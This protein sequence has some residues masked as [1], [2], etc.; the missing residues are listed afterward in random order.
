[1]SGRK[2]GAIKSTMVASRGGPGGGGGA[3]PPLRVVVAPTAA[4]PA[5]KI[6]WT[7]PAS[8][9]AGAP[10]DIG[11]VAASATGTGGPLR[12]EFPLGAFAIGQAG[13]NL[14][15]V[16]PGDGVA[17]LDGTETATVPVTAIP[18]TIVSAMPAAPV[19]RGTA[20]TAAMFSAVPSAG[21]GVVV[22]SQPV[23]AT[24]A[25]VGP[26]TVVLALAAAG[27]H[28][29]APPVSHVIN[30]LLPKRVITW[31]PP[32]SHVYAAPL[33]LVTL[34]ASA[35]GL[36][37]D[38]VLSY[39]QG[40]LAVVQ[41]GINLK[42]TAPG[43]AGEWDAAEETATVAV[44]PAPRTLTATAP[45]R[46]FKTGAVVKASH[47]VA[48]ASAGDEEATVT[49]P[50][51]GKLLVVGGAVDVVL[52]LPAGNYAA[53]T[54]TVQVQVEP[55]RPKLTLTSTA[56]TVVQN[57]Q[58]ATTWL[59]AAIEPDTLAG[60][61]VFKPALGTALAHLGPATISVEFL[62]DANFLRVRP[63][64]VR[65]AICKNADVK[66]GSDDM[67]DATKARAAIKPMYIDAKTT[68]LL[69]NWA[70]DVG[71]VAT[72][73]RKVMEDI[74]NM[75]SDELV[76]YMDK[77]TGRRTAG[78]S[79]D[80]QLWELGNGLQVRYKANGDAFHPSKH[81]CMEVS[82]VA[83]S[84]GPQ[85]IAFK[86]TLGGMPGPVGREVVFPA[87]VAGTTPR[88]DYVNGVLDMTHPRVLAKRKP[89]IDW[90]LADG[91][92]I[93][94]GENIDATVWTATSLLPVSYRVGRNPTPFNPGDKLL[95]P[96]ATEIHAVTEPTDKYDVGRVTRRIT[97]KR[98]S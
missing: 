62:G 44:T 38:P 58:V 27:N 23:P 20:L 45:A 93:Y 22:M 77:R 42:I 12:L 34:G 74:K 32:A 40:P 86:V 9:E 59:T 3:M 78:K 64:E 72:T 70:T 37:G 13:I 26:L 68:E 57:T 8:I 87:G 50:A 2:G 54:A 81:F 48:T 49:S 90:P 25:A 14:R 85:D 55:G 28:A 92:E 71:G 39:P 75:T 65:L 97:V 16:A 94:A 31:T 30:V 73:G 15:I 35:T 80:D 60:S 63:V 46:A 17:F 96:G 29:A 53:A 98:R 1:M 11:A 69:T 47:L 7:P 6:T 18:R 5:R 56:T 10:L 91:A 19:I 88:A 76:K 67:L 41:T 51:G 89:E 61:L 83:K 82:K 21:G 24:A 36:G 52:D 66:Q 4:L 95:A 79:S 33:D 84:A 43:L